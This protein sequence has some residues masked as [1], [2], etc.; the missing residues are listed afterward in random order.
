MPLLVILEVNMNKPIATPRTRINSASIAPL[1][2][3]MM[4]LGLW[5]GFANNAGGQEPDAKY[6]QEYAQSFKGV[7]ANSKDFSLTGPDAD[8]HVK[9]EPDGLRITL[10]AGYVG[11]RPITGLVT[12]FGVQGDF[13]ITLSYEILK[14]PAAA[15][16][17]SGGTRLTLG[18]LLHTAERNLAQLSR[19]VDM[20]GGLRFAAWAYTS[21]KDQPRNK[22]VAAKAKTGRLR[23]TRAGNVLSYFAADGADQ[24]FTLLQKFPFGAEDVREVRITGA[25]GGDKAALE[26]RVIDLRIRAAALPKTLEPLA[27]P[28]LP[29]A[30]PPRDLP[31]RV[32]VPFHQGIDEQPLMRLFGPD[33]KA[34]MKRNEQGMRFTLP[35]QRNSNAPV[36]LE[37]QLCLRGDFEITVSYELLGIPDPAPPLGAGVEMLVKFDAPNLARALMSRV[38]KPTGPGFGANFVTT[39]PDGKD[40]FKG[41]SFREAKQSKGKMRL[42][43]AGKKLIYQIADGDGGFLVIATKDFGAEDVIAVRLHA[44]TGWQMKSGV[45]VRFTNLTLR[46]EQILKSVPREFAEGIEI[47][48]RDGIEKHPWLRLDGSDAPAIAK[49]DAQGLRF[50]VP[51][52]RDDNGEVGVASSMRL[53]G[54]FEITMQY[55][56]LALPD[57][58][59]ELGAGVA[60]QIQ[61]DTPD[62]FKVHLNRNRNPNGPVYGANYL[63]TDKDGKGIFKGISVYH[64]NEHEKQGSLRLVRKGKRLSYQIAEG[65]APFMTIESKDIGTADVILARALCNTGWKSDV[66]VDIRFIR[67]ELRA[68]QMPNKAAPLPAP[69]VGAPDAPAAATPEAASKSW[70]VAFLIVGVALVMLLAIAAG[71]WLFLRSRRLEEPVRGRRQKPDT[72]N[73]SPWA[74]FPCPDCDRKIKVKA[75]LAGKKVKC[76]KCG[77]AVLV[78][79]VTA[80][81]IDRASS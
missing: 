11:D 56:L 3:A 72:V 5:I 22:G 28:P 80:D 45:D 34:A 53:R 37:S 71:L 33:V 68:D 64:A 61:L 40:N 65:T 32:E 63:F 67:L 76:P 42:V 20:K 14:E 46:A 55:E 27:P 78:P 70:L 21:D 16:A 1:P 17:G 6:A 54:D 35:D 30:P 59:P 49:T 29:P 15:D 48:L 39:G 18:V 51:A 31:E 8:K 4:I 47:Q 43:R 38:Q 74:V 52:G 25:T 77:Q 57:P 24:D 75:A 60:L 62:L 10:P 58:P 81:E 13:E 69:P 23:L 44:T 41:L 36:G 50:L 66:S 7:P 19:K 9:F 12:A 2:L 73:V 79:A 26:V